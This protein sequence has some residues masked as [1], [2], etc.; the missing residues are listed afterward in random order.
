MTEESG[1]AI[2]PV[3]Y[4]E[5]DEETA[6]HVVTHKGQKY[7]FCTASC[8]K[9]F[10]EKPEKYTKLGPISRIDPGMTC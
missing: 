1:M 3:C 7:Y 2:D 9:K 10:E 4:A 5:V 6:S 8:R